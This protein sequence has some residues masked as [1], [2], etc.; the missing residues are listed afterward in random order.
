MKQE[1]SGTSP[2]SRPVDVARPTGDARLDALA[3]LVAIVD[4]L[5]DPGGCPWDREQTVTSMAPSLVEEAF[6]AVEAID[7]A[8][9]RATAEEL[10]DLLMVVALVARIAGEAGRFDLGTVAGAVGDKLV[11]RHPHVFGTVEVEGAEHA[12]RNWEAIKQGERRSKDEDASALAGVPAALPALQRADRIGA[13]AISAGFRWTD[14]AGAL[15]K[16]REEVSELAE[17]LAREPRDPARLEAELGD[18]LLAAAF[19]G[20]YAGVDPERAARGAVRRFEERFRRMEG[21][22]GAR[23]KTAGA[24]ELERAWE[25][26]KSEGGT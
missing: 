2:A 26:A 3:K 21:E 9:D 25:R 4:R 20:R 1:E 17:E 14:A 11:R 16:L 8:D 15:E 12:V 18:V 23:L 10:G 13:K 22:L 6:E 19:V 5:R 7:R 24:S